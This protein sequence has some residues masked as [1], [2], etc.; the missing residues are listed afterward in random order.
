MARRKEL[1]EK[2]D[3]PW[4]GPMMR[5]GD[6]AKGSGIPEVLMTA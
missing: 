5:A 4:G 1:E 2:P 6:S 3:I